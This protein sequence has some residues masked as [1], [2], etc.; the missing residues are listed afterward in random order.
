MGRPVKSRLRE[1]QPEPALGLGHNVGQLRIGLTEDHP[2]PGGTVPLPDVLRE[3]HQQG[4][5]FAPA[6]C[7]V[8]QD[9][10]QGAAHEINPTARLG[11]PGNTPRTVVGKRRECGQT[12]P[13]LAGLRLSVQ[14]GPGRVLF[15]R[16]RVD[17][18]GSD[19]TPC[20]A[21]KEQCGDLTIVSYKG[22]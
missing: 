10:E 12:G 3:A 21:K 17:S 15:R 16:G 11:T 9:L 18:E 14:L 20:S 8:Q 4:I 2:A 7:P 6:A 1:N 5:A 22:Q 13:L 19:H